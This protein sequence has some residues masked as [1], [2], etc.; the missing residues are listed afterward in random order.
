MEQINAPKEV[1]ILESAD[2]IQERRE[3]VLTW[4]G[5]FKAEARTKRV[6]LEDS[7]RFQVSL[8]LV[9]SWISFSVCFLCSFILEL[10]LLC[11]S[12]YSTSNEMLMN[13][14]FGSMRNCKQPQMKATR[15]PQTF[16]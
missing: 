2:D 10:I 1:K 9:L 5:E 3:Q 15:I 4:Y 7:R 14:N 12:H 16:R 11:A 6:K 13:W 8:N